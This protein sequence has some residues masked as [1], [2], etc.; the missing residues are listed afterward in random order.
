MY[1]GQNP[2]TQTSTIV[3]AAAAVGV[4]LPAAVLAAHQKATGAIKG[5]QGI[6]PK[7]G[8]AGPVAAALIAG[9]DPATDPDVMRTFLA[10]Q[11]GTH[12]VIGMVENILNEEM[13]QEFAVHADAIVNAWTKPFDQAAKVLTDAHSHLGDI[14]LSD[15]AVIVE[16]GGSAAEAWGRAQAATRTINT[17]TD[18]WLALGEFARLVR[19]DPRYPVLRIAAVDAETWREAQLDRKRLAPWDAVIAGLTLSLPSM[20]Q[21]GER[22]TTVE[23]GLAQLAAAEA[24][25]DRGREQVREFAGRVHAARA[26][27]RVATTL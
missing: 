16:R 19:L 4:G 11:I 13:R 9:R 3:N 27:S 20:A 7:G 12:E 5:L 17:I 2:S 21:Y 14:D 22:I 23:R 10:M 26:G 6:Y 15:T 8:L 25:I 24:P 18:A 1:L